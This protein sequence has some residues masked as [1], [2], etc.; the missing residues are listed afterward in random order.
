MN[1]EKYIQNI[2]DN[3]LACLVKIADTRANLIQ[4]TKDGDDKR[5]AK[6]TKQLRLLRGEE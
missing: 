2:K 1:Y 5:I 3:N 4:S 6:Y